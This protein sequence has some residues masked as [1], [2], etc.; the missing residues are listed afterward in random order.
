MKTATY[1]LPDQPRI[2]GME[3]ESGALPKPA[4]MLNQFTVRSVGGATNDI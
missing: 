4:V 1:G 2:L 3:N